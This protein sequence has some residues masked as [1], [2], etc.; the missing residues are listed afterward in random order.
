MGRLDCNRGCYQVTVRDTAEDT[1]V[2]VRGTVG[3]CDDGWRA[4]AASG[5]DWCSMLVWCCSVCEEL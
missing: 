5:D 4:A 1:Y 3:H 2:A